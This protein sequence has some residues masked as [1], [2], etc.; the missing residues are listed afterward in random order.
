MERMQFMCKDSSPICKNVVSNSF[1]QQRNIDD[2]THRYV[3]YCKN[4][5]ISSHIDDA[6]YTHSWE[7]KLKFLNDLR[8]SGHEVHFIAFSTLN[9]NVDTD[10]RRMVERKLLGDTETVF[11]NDE[12]YYK[13]VSE[14]IDIENPAIV[15]SDVRFV[16]KDATD[17]HIRK[18]TAMFGENSY[19]I[20]M[21]ELYVQY[22]K[23]RVPFI[24]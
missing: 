20:L 5:A 7:K 18:V 17:E 6:L 3:D 24:G 16:F 12:I 19:D 4:T 10:I 22:A 13:K 2:K 1:K 14:T 23:V 9:Q 15:R 11:F 8:K 21:S